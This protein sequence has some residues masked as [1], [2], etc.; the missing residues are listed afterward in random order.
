MALI[1]N[2]GICEKLRD[3]CQALPATLITCARLSGKPF[4]MLSSSRMLN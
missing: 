4:R 3:D 1:L 2:T